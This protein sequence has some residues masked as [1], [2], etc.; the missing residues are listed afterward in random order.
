MGSRGGSGQRSSLGAGTYLLIEAAVDGA[1]ADLHEPLGGDEHLVH[2]FPWKKPSQAQQADTAPPRARAPDLPTAQHGRTFVHAGGRADGAEVAVANHLGRA[3]VSSCGHTVLPQ[4]ERP[5][6]RRPP[7]GAGRG[8]LCPHCP[9]PDWGGWGGL[10]PCVPSRNTRGG[11]W[12]CWEEAGAGVLARGFWG[13]SGGR[14]AE[15][16]RGRVGRSWVSCHRAGPAGLRPHSPPGGHHPPAAALRS[17]PCGPGPRW[18]GRAALPPALQ[19][20]GCG[21]AQV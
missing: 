5:S 1:P 19:G 4:G 10:G 16:S 13:M 17:P 14:G 11:S 12:P 7:R 20:G 2:P 9:A 8:P 6:L 3:G 18:R 15:D 21:R